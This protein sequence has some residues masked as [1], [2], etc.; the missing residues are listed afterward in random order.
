MVK[1]I[2][3]FLL[4]QLSFQE[5]ITLSDN[6][7]YE[8]QFSN[9]D[10]D[11]IFSTTAINITKSYIQIKTK[12][13]SNQ[14][15]I[16]VNEGDYEPDFSNHDYASIQFIN[17]LFYIPNSV[18]KD[19]KFT[20]KII[21]LGECNFQIYIKTTDTIEINSNEI[22][23]I[24]SSVQ[25]LYDI[26]ID[27]GDPKSIISITAITG[28][29][30]EISLSL[31]TK[32]KEIEK[33]IL[34][35]NGLTGKGVMIN[36]NDFDSDTNIIYNGKLVSIQNCYIIISVSEISKI[37]KISPYVNS[38]YGH[39]NQNDLL[40]NGVCYE[41]EKKTNSNNFRLSAISDKDINI[42]LT[43]NI[44]SDIGKNIP[45]KSYYQNYFDFNILNINEDEYK[46]I[47]IK[48]EKNENIS[49]IMQITDITKLDIGNFNVDPLLN[50]FI[51]KDELKPNEIRQY[52]KMKY[53]SKT[54][55]ET[56]YNV[57]VISGDV[58]VYI[59]LCDKFPYCNNTIS[60]LKEK[61]LEQSLIVPY[62]INNFYSAGIMQL[63]KEKYSKGKQYL[64]YVICN[65]NNINSC[66]YEVS[67]FDEDDSLLLR[68]D[69]KV[70]EYI[71]FGNI[72]YQY[73]FKIEDD[74]AK[75]VLVSLYTMSGDINFTVVSTEKKQ[76]KIQIGNVNIIKFT[77]DNQKLNGI[78]NINITGYKNSFY[79]LSYQIITDDIKTE[80]EDVG[81]GIT[82]IKSI[83]PNQSKIFKFTHNINNL[84]NNFVSQFFPINCKIKI[85]YKN[86]ILTSTN[87][88]F[89][90]ELTKTDLDFSDNEIEYKI[91]FESMDQSETF[92]NKLCFFYLSS[93]EI[94][95]NN[96]VLINDLL[97][98][99]F[100]LNTK[101]PKIKL[102]YPYTSNEKEVFIGINL[103]SQFTIASKIFI[104]NREIIEEIQFSKYKSF[105]IDKDKLGANCKT[106]SECNILIEIYSKSDLKKEIKLYISIDPRTKTP[107]YL[108]KSTLRKDYI[109][110]GTTNYYM[111]EIAENEEGEI[112]INFERG[113]GKM[114][115][116]IVKK[117]EYEINPDWNGRVNLPK[118]NSTNLLKYDPFTKKIYYFKNNTNKCKSGCDLFLGVITKDTYQ[119]EIESMFY[120]KYTLYLRDLNKNKNEEIIEIPVNEYIYGAIEKTIANNYYDYYKITIPHSTD[121]IT[122]EFQTQICA[123]YI[124][125]GDNFPNAFENDW[126]FL[127]EN[128]LNIIKKGDKTEDGRII[129]DDLKGLNFTI[130]VGATDLDDI[131]TAIYSFN[132]RANLLKM[133]NIIDVNSDQNTICQIRNDSDYCDFLLYFNSFE[134]YD[135]L[136][137]YVLNTGI[138]NVEIYG[139]KIEIEKF[140]KMN[141]SE[142]EKQLPRKNSTDL[143]YNSTKQFN[144]KYLYIDFSDISQ[145]EYLLISVYSPKKTTITL[146][147][148]LRTY[149]KT[150]IPNP[151]YLQLFSVTPNNPISLEIDK[152]NLYLFNIYS[153]DG[154]GKIGFDNKEYYDLYGTRDSIILL[155]DKKKNY[156][157]ITSNENLKVMFWNYITPEKRHL[158][159]IEFGSSSK[160]ININND[161]PIH[162]YTKIE[163]KNSDINLN[164][165]FKKIKLKNNNNQFKKIDNIFLLNGY[166]IDEF[167]FIK[168][169]KD[170]T[171]HPGEEE[172]IE[173]NY[174]SSIQKAKIYI[175]SSD[176]KKKE[177]E[178]LY[179]YF[180]LLKKGSDIY[181]ECEIE[182]SN[183]PFSNS[184]SPINQYVDGSFLLNQ[185]KPNIHYLKKEKKND[186]KMRIEFSTSS[187]EIN[188]AF[189]KDINKINKK[190]ND[191][192][193]FISQ[194]NI[195]GKSLFYI[196]S[197][198]FDG[199]YLSV[200]PKGN[201]IEKEISSNYVFKYNSYIN[202][203]TTINDIIADENGIITYEYNSSKNELN[204]IIPSLIEKKSNKS[205]LG[206]YF[207]RIFKEDT[208]SNMT[209][210]DTISFITEQPFD[211]Y[212]FTSKEKKT[213]NINNINSN[214]NYSISCIG[215][216]ENGEL[217]SYKSIVT[218]IQKKPNPEPPKSS[219][220]NLVLIIILIIVIIALIIVF[221]FIL[222][223]MKKD[224]D[225]LQER[226]NTLSHLDE[227]REKLVENLNEDVT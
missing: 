72:F 154:T 93:Q 190:E 140:D 66:K 20:I 123:M 90:H 101:V 113:G 148:T 45:F 186:K 8:K 77:N 211:S 40:K 1:F 57:R 103:P 58:K 221:A 87:S 220:D 166:I 195:N 2:I 37:Q 194:E 171:V 36:Q 145:N 60:E 114:F 198:D 205:I 7:P 3:I 18:I 71:K 39:F 138:T 30:N 206:Q 47:C 62:S 73:H 100:K 33:E 132:V 10:Y 61:E 155:S 41:I 104:E 200:F 31:N 23:T 102:L 127:G 15:L 184:T 202:E 196:N 204:L 176:I 24:F 79:Y 158:T 226:I 156:L 17:N 188:F 95:N 125:L 207:I 144:K 56:K 157:N 51:Y 16:Y 88:L 112:L 5:D 105:I 21:C 133:L 121:K 32:I 124:S 78:Y 179:V 115:G 160:I 35:E 94:S 64:L 52:R 68:E 182:V 134:T 213:I 42:F 4:F 107:S 50:G 212:Q 65:E 55:Q 6:E 14:A 91:I 135:N 149:V 22:V 219:Y 214:Q 85:E 117:T 46:Y 169:K 44:S 122:F 82:L 163:D 38:I 187:K 84:N 74:K 131:Y 136:F 223:K 126:E 175:K 159:E 118:E 225:I 222:I 162:L 34:F 224:K 69:F 165:Y 170:H 27:G 76:E 89:Q 128:T 143:K 180:N 11:I 116:K 227:G 193:N 197:S 75:E 54:T 189:I 59:Y 218:N 67:F 215:K 130:A 13:L 86:K 63:T 120:S 210:L 142:I 164:L 81:L 167:M 173:G 106:K 153:I 119:E 110:V 49:Y 129:P 151:N 152:A 178:V 146:I 192:I 209:T 111:T 97:P 26:K 43:D 161:F 25:K 203:N 201:K 208:L 80:K 99:E 150:T 139:K 174:D 19:N 141:K 9:P 216:T 28:A 70:S 83:K 168:M 199:I 172:K 98:F 185:E 29:K 181:E 177:Q 92:D 53:A 108:K 48:G 191:T 109:N 137:I 147:N 217:I 12:A 96:Q 183:L